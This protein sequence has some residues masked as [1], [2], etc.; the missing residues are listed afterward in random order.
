M[1]EPGLSPELERLK[2]LIVAHPDHIPVPRSLKPELQLDH[3]SDPSQLCIEVSP[4][5]PRSKSM[6]VNWSA[7]AAAAADPDPSP[8]RDSRGDKVRP[9]AKSSTVRAEQAFTRTCLGPI[10]CYG[11]KAKVLDLYFDDTTNLLPSEQR[12]QGVGMYDTNKVHVRRFLHVCQERAVAQGRSFNAT[13][14]DVAYWL[15]KEGAN[16][17]D[18]LVKAYDAKEAK[19]STMLQLIQSLKT[20]TAVVKKHLPSDASGY[21]ETMVALDSSFL[22]HARSR[23]AELKRA[24]AKVKSGRTEEELSKTGHWCSVAELHEVQQKSYDEFNAGIAALANPNRD[25]KSITKTEL[26][27]VNQSFSVFMTLHCR[28]GRPSVMQALDRDVLLA[29]LAKPDGKRDYT[30]WDHKLTLTT[31]KNPVVSFNGD[32]VYRALMDYDEVYRAAVANRAARL[33]LDP[34][35]NVE[36]TGHFLANSSYRPANY[37][38]AFQQGFRRLTKGKGPKGEGLNISINNVRS[39]LATEVAKLAHS[40]VLNAE[41]TRT[42]TLT[43]HHSEETANLYYAKGQAS[44]EQEKALALQRKHFLPPPK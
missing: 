31:G 20:L 10:P 27:Y 5:R 22:P 1:G 29:V 35:E 42:L 44:R 25:P 38:K 15:T 21:G 24:K 3:R 14:P 4:P 17:L 7:A 41:D 36:A 13:V 18:S 23:A 39:I 16:I 34:E 40:G 30:A 26:A 8:K 32:I 19:A 9:K 33:R 11:E 37:G 43:D 12:S 6:G 28:T 2:L